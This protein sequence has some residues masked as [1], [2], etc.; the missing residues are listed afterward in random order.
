[1][2]EKALAYFSGINPLANKILEDC[3]K[4]ELECESEWEN[5]DLAKREEMLDDFLVH[6]FVKDRYRDQDS[7]EKDVSFPKLVLPCGE[8]I[9]VD[10]DNDVSS[11][12][13]VC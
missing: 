8:K 10:F 1:M 5:W 12:H 6:S 11:A 2:E 9:I 7:S 13:S 4:V 3:K